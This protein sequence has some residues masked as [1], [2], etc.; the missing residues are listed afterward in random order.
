MLHAIQPGSTFEYVPKECQDLEDDDPERVVFEI[1]H[2]TVSELA[3]VE[4]SIGAY[5]REDDTM[6]MKVGSQTLVALRRGLR[7]WRN[8][9]FSDGTEAPFKTNLISKRR[10]KERTTEPEPTDETLGMIPSPIRTELMNAITEG[11]RVS[12]E[13]KGN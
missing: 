10:G 7:G 1:K 6:K 13:E 9:S 3:E 4:D 5:D 12:E 8:F 2:L 11:N